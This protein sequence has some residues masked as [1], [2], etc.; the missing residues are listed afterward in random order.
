[1]ELKITYTVKN[2]SACGIKN[3]NNVE[4]NIQYN[5]VRIPLK[6]YRKIEKQIAKLEKIIYLGAH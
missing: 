4:T 5:G 1:M 2:N 6:V 3:S